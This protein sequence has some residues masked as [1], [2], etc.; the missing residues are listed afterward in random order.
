MWQ[1]IRLLLSLLLSLLLLLLLLKCSLLDHL[2]SV[3]DELS[4]LVLWNMLA[5]RYTLS[6]LLHI[7]HGNLS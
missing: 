6:H 7:R 3:H 1:G 4:D 5:V 2:L